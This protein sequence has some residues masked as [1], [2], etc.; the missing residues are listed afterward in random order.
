M[1]AWDA[2]WMF[3]TITGMATVALVVVTVAWLIMPAKRARKPR[4]DVYRG[5][6]A[7]HLENR[8]VIRGNGTMTP[9]QYREWCESL[10]REGT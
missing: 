8:V 1:T 4:Q 3:F 9:Q 7:E 6:V 10:D 2:V 5:S